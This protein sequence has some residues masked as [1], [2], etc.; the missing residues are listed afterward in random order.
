LSTATPVMTNGGTSALPET[1]T[2]GPSSVPSFHLNTQQVLDMYYRVIC[3]YPSLKA[4]ERSDLEYHLNNGM[5]NHELST[6]LFAIRTLC[7][8]RIG[9]MD[10]AEESMVMARDGLASIFFES[11]VFVV[12]TYIY[13][14]I[15]ESGCGRY[16]LARYY[17]TFVKI[18]IREG[19][20]EK[21]E[22]KYE[23]LRKLKRACGLLEMV[24]NDSLLMDFKQ[25]PATFE[26]IVGFSLPQ[27]LVQ[28]L[29]MDIDITNYKSFFKV[30]DVIASYSDNGWETASE[31]ELKIHNLLL[32]FFVKGLKL[33]VMK[34]CGN[35][36]ALNDERELLAFLQTNTTQDE[37]FPILCTAP[38]TSFV[39][40]TAQI[41][42]DIVKSIERGERVNPSSILLQTSDGLT[43][44]L[45]ID[46]YDI[47]QKDQR[48]LQS[49]SKK[50]KKV[51]LFHSSLLKELSNIVHI[52]LVHQLDELQN[53][54]VL[55]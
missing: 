4:I 47:L 2:E 31:F 30:I 54:I 1:P 19:M 26:N 40:T 52:R 51:E 37:L 15:Y 13:L 46:Y 10:A 18:Y 35:N 39:V 3:M 53:G 22:E 5:V 23:E 29:N 20:A 28:L 9:M 50:Y 24:S 17:F 36:P 42:L 11:S 38:L 34:K 8:Q 49:L 25:W 41:H 21:R 48:A 33:E 6:M 14:C 27:E 43:I 12:Y 7:E 44:P 16:A 45:L 32:P 55:H